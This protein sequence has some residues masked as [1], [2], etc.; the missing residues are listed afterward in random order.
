MKNEKTESNVNFLTFP[1][2]A[3]D[4]IIFETI[5]VVKKFESQSKHF[6][7]NLNQRHVMVRSTSQ[8]DIGQSDANE[9]QK[10]ITMKTFKDI[11]HFLENTGQAAELSPVTLK[12]Q[13]LLVESSPESY[14]GIKLLFGTYVRSLS[15]IASFIAF[16]DVINESAKS[17]KMA[18]KAIYMLQNI[19]LPPLFFP[20]FESKMSF[21]LPIR[22][23][24]PIISTAVATSESYIFIGK[25]ESTIEQISFNKSKTD[26]SKFI[27]IP[28]PLDSMY[29]LVYINGYLIVCGKNNP[30]LLLDPKSE[31]HF[32]IPI[33]FQGHFFASSNTFSPPLVSDGKFLYSVSFGNSPRVKIFMFELSCIRFVKYIPLVTGL[34]KGSPRNNDLLPLKHQY[35]AP[36]ATNGVYLSVILQEPTDSIC[37]IFNLHTGYHLHDV[38]LSPSFS[39][40]SWVFD[41]NRPAHCI[42]NEKSAI[43]LDSCF[44]LP[45]WLA[46]FEEPPEL[47]RSRF[48]DTSCIIQAYCESL[49]RLALHCIG[50]DVNLHLGLVDQLYS[51]SIET[52][53]CRFI[54]SENIPGSQAFLVFLAMKLRS[55]SV[56]YSFLYPVLDRFVKCIHNEKLSELRFLVVF[57]FLSS[58]D[59]FFSTNIESSSDMLIQ[60]IN[61][62]RYQSILFRFLP[63]SQFL[64]R[65]L[66]EQSLLGIC[67]ITLKTCFLFN[68]LASSLL[69]ELQYNFIMSKSHNSKLFLVYLSKL[70]HQFIDDYSH[71]SNGSWGY[72]RLTSSV[73]FIVLN[74]LIKIMMSTKEDRLYNYEIIR[75]LFSIGCL[76]YPQENSEHQSLYELLLLSLFL[77][78]QFSFDGIQQDN[79][80]IRIDDSGSDSVYDN[81]PFSTFFGNLNNNI[82]IPNEEIYSSVIECIYKSNRLCLSDQ[83]ICE[84]VS[85]VFA[86]IRAEKISVCDIQ[87]RINIINKIQPQICESVINFL[88]GSFDYQLKTQK[89]EISTFTTIILFDEKLMKPIPQRRAVFGFFLKNINQISNRFS[90]LPIRL[91]EVFVS[92]FSLRFFLDSSFFFISKYH[93]EADLIIQMP[94]N[95]LKSCISTIFP[96]SILI[97]NKK[98]LIAPFESLQ[99][100]DVFSPKKAKDIQKAILL[101]LIAFTGG[102]FEISSVELFNSTSLLILKTGNYEIIDSLLNVITKISYNFSIDLSP[103]LIF[104]FDSIVAMFSRVESMFPGNQ[105]IYIIHQVIHLVADFFRSNVFKDNTIYRFLSE[106]ISKAKSDDTF[107]IFAIFNNEIEI[108]RPGVWISFETD[109][110]DIIEGKVL[111]FD[112]ISMKINIEG[113]DEEYRISEETH[114]TLKSLSL[115]D[116]TKG[117]Y[118]DEFYKLYFNTNIVN[119]LH[120]VLWISSLYSFLVVAEFRSYIKSSD[121]SKLTQCVSF[122]HQL[123]SYSFNDLSLFF[124]SSKEGSSPFRFIKR[125]FVEKRDKPS[126]PFIY[127]IMNSYFASDE[128]STES[129]ISFS[130][131]ITYNSPA[132]HSTCNFI[133][134]MSLDQAC[135]SKSSLVIYSLSK[136]RG[137]RFETNSVIFSKVRII[138]KYN[139]KRLYIKFDDAQEVYLVEPLCD[140]IFVSIT[141]SENSMMHYTFRKSEEYFYHYGEIKRMNHK[142][143]FI[144]VFPTYTA[145]DF[146]TYHA[147]DLC[148]KVSSE[149]CK[150]V[151]S[152][153]PFFLQYISNDS[154][155]FQVYMHLLSHID[156]NPY[157]VG[158]NVMSIL[159]ED[160]S[161]QNSEKKRLINYITNELCKDDRLYK[162]FFHHMFTAFEEQ[163]AQSQIDFLWDENESGAMVS[164]TEFINKNQYYV[165]EKNGN[166]KGSSSVSQTA[167]FI[168][169][170]CNIFCSIL[171]LYNDIKHLLLVLQKSSRSN[172]ECDEK[173]YKIRGYIVKCKNLFGHEL[174]D[175]LLTLSQLMFPES[176]P[177][178]SESESIIMKMFPK[179]FI[180]NKVCYR[181]NLEQLLLPYYNIRRFPFFT[182]F[183]QYLKSN[184]EQVTFIQSQRMISFQYYPSNP[185]EYIFFMIGSSKQDESEMFE[186]SYVES[187]D[188]IDKCI[189]MGGYIILPPK[190]FCFRPKNPRYEMKNLLIYWKAFSYTEEEMIDCLQKE[191][192]LWKPQYSRQV[193]LSIP[194]GIMQID[195]EIYENLPLSSL[196]S[197]ET[198]SYYFSV[199]KHVSKPHEMVGKHYVFFQN[200]FSKEIVND[201]LQKMKNPHIDPKIPL[202]ALAITSQDSPPNLS[203]RFYND[204]SKGTKNR[205]FTFFTGLHDLS[206]GDL[207]VRIRGTKPEDVR[208][209]LRVC[210]F[211]VDSEVEHLLISIIEKMT[212]YPILMFIDWVTGFWGVESLISSSKPF[213][214]FEISSNQNISLIRDHH[215]VKVGCFENEKELRM[216]LMKQIQVYAD[217]NE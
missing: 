109:K 76:D 134:D 23:S 33:S 151:L 195:Q 4:A 191:I 157:D 154:F 51:N 106:K 50:S 158:S 215:V 150:K 210:V 175:E 108:I 114:V 214:V 156:P 168:I 132:I 5:S 128:D 82:T 172:N 58:L 59:A 71:F 216:E 115:F 49:S 15:L 171:Q 16:R 75:I 110:K 57:T 36:I 200:S 31:T 165:L 42:V 196:F 17:I 113:I 93:P 185:N 176:K 159:F 112:H 7:D 208:S 70:H 77:S 197:M 201:K 139:Q 206:S 94:F 149:Y 63:K 155:I 111:F 38:N 30:A 88:L 24:H 39:I 217:Q 66:S 84:L 190:S 28:Q 22:N 27:R 143:D 169:D 48:K 136:S 129:V 72:N 104:L 166:I 120:N 2:V 26:F 40:L 116:P 135:S 119:E 53:L 160:S 61:D 11:E 98:K 43:M 204:V 205:V 69:L 78:I 118:F 12:M 18:K 153:Y 147:K 189:E 96:I 127:D 173:L 46:G 13:V 3:S 97:L 174:L 179:L 126:L 1:K 187:F 74:D 60:T 95:E 101:L 20:D 177:D 73:S 184:S 21:I 180:D 90:I 213:I 137:I 202:S 186:I 8:T 124:V 52:A 170:K 34:F 85:N 41:I 45:P 47:N 107:A 19:P 9:A 102:C 130:E 144:S 192:L 105:S 182:F 91:I 80:F 183:V 29:S 68:D 86:C 54:D 138:Y 64:T 199:L 142:N 62:N 6:L 92:N 65:A 117:R 209:L 181:F 79:S 125:N 194:D 37:R 44:T 188:T 131:P 161:Y 121:I 163:I 141:L 25:N 81:I 140:M 198:V 148:K 89:E 56:Q 83:R 123:L 178:V 103:V 212:H 87:S 35:S 32:S 152:Y 193:L 203:Q 14:M 133:L 207:K 164:N 167:L 211:H 162:K 145:S 55:E 122:S 10:L 99:P 67:N 100:Y 146:I